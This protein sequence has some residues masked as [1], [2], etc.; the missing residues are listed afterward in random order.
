MLLVDCL[1]SPPWW[2]Q[3]NHNLGYWNLDNIWPI[4]ITIHNLE[5]N[6]PWNFWIDFSATKLLFILIDCYL[7][8]SWIIWDQTIEFHVQSN[9][10]HAC[11]DK[12]Y[13]FCLKN[14]RFYILCFDKES[15]IFLFH[16]T[17][18]MPLRIDCVVISLSVNGQSSRGGA[19]L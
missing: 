11:I 14:H 15:K 18:L 19:H 2:Q 8:Q 9:S 6:L 7:F 3:A 4:F 17:Y 10:F 1:S 5:R 12:T 13:I 16:T